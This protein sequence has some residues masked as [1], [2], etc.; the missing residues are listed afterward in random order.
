MVTT[1]VAYMD[2][3]TEAY[4]QH[5]QVVRDGHG[6]YDIH[7]YYDSGICTVVSIHGW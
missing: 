3:I 6:I 7:G 5:S 1:N 2:T 4:S